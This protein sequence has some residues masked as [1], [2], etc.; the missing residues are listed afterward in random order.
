MNT[1][2]KKASKWIYFSFIFIM[3]LLCTL[4]IVSPHGDND[5]VRGATIYYPA[6]DSEIGQTFMVNGSIYAK[7]GIASAEMVFLP[8]GE[9]FPIERETIEYDGKTLMT[10]STFKNEVTLSSE[11][12][13]GMQVNMV[14]TTGETYTLDALSFEVKQG[15]LAQA[16]RMFS[17]MHLIPLAVLLGVFFLMLWLYRRKPSERARIIMFAIISSLVMACDVSLK[18]WMLSK[19]LL[20]ASYDLIFHMCD[21]SGFLLP[22]LLFMK[23]GKY[24]EA[25]FDLM[26][27]WGLGGAA[28]A[29]LTPE[30]GGYVFPSLYYFNFFIKHG[31]IV[32]GV[33]MAALVDGLRPSLKKMPTAIGL[34][35]IIVA[36]IYGID[37]LMVLLPPYELGNYMFLSYPPT[38]GSLIDLLVTVFGPS[39]YYIIGLVI[40]AVIV[41]VVLWVPFAIV[42]AVKRTKG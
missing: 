31:M 20:R 42:G 15:A 17:P 38:G 8:S 39:P 16:F 18:A 34:S 21:I 14:T 4:A 37:R 35:V 22:V 3:V 25:L 27:I 6:Q 23:P 5:F 36:I 1:T 41:Y 24:R 29:L 13:M 7:D 33:L 28:M 40:V 19:G 30:M 11:G 26:F 32:I 10:L 2:Q 9:R 12:A